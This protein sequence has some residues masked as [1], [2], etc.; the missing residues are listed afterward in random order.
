MRMEVML[1]VAIISISIM[2]NIFGTEY[3]E[4]DLEAGGLTK[5]PQTISFI[6]HIFSHPLLQ[7]F[8]TWNF[9]CSSK[10]MVYVG[11]YGPAAVTTCTIY[12]YVDG[13]EVA[14]Q[15][16]PSLGVDEVKPV[17]SPPLPATIG[18]HKVRVEIYPPEGY[19]DPD[20]YNNVDEG[21][22]WFLYA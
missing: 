2:P 21:D 4:A 9:S 16:G 7:S 17:I 20:C 11:N 15:N 14:K 1:I 10:F 3:Q 19:T 18:K 8:F 5:A 12:W 22:F 13:K 6:H